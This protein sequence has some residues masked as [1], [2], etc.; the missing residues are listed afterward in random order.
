MLAIIGKIW[1]NQCMEID[2]LISELKSENAEL[3]A[4][5]SALR[6]DNAEIKSK[7][8]WLVEQLSSNKRKLYGSSSEKSVYDFNG[9][10]VGLFDEGTTIVPLIE[11]EESSGDTPTRNR[12]KKQGEMGS[13]LPADLPVEI[14]E[15]ALNEEEQECPKGHGTMRVIGKEL[16]RRELKIIPAKAVVKEFWRFSYLCNICEKTGDGSAPIVKAELPPQVIKGSMCAPE[17]VAHITVEKCIMGS[18]LYRQEA[19]WNR[20]GI[21]ITR[22]TMASWLIRCSEDYLEPVY[23]CK[24]TE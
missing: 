10:Q 8:D 1:Y 4:E 17:T 3:R 12:P 24:G 19:A 11:T 9:A 21:Q 6:A 13:R 14:V 23:D 7:L 15:C 16:V 20:L 5:N 2:V 22:Q 18:P